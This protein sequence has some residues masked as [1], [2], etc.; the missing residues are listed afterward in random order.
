MKKFIIPLLIVVLLIS[1]VM[2][3][4]SCKKEAAETTTAAE[5]VTEET[6]ATE[7]TAAETT[8]EPK[9]SGSIHFLAY[10]W[11]AL[12]D[13]TLAKYTEATGVEVT[14]EVLGYNELNTKF[15][16]SSAAGIVA[17]DVFSTYVAP[18]AAHVA[19][20]YVEPLDSYISDELRND[21]LGIDVFTFN[22]ILYGVPTYYDITC[23]MYNKELLQNAGID[24]PPQ[25]LDELFQQCMDIKNAGVCEYPLAV[26]LAA[27]VGM[28]DRWYNIALAYGG[29]PLFDEN[30]QPQFTAKDSGGYKALEFMKQANGTIIDPALIDA[31]DTNVN[32]IFLAG[33]AVFLVGSPGLVTRAEDP[34]VSKIVGEKVGL[35]LFPGSD[36][37]RSATLN[38]Y[39]D[40]MSVSSL[41]ENK[42]AAW[43]FIEW[44]NTAEIAEDAYKDLGVTP[45]RKSLLETFINRGLV[46]G[47]TF[48]AEQSEYGMAIFQSGIPVWFDEWAQDAAGQLNKAIRG[49]MSIDEALTKMANKAIEMQE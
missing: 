34:E 36:K 8:A 39:L 30:Y 45:T 44:W 48:I 43:A 17:A 25:T 27:H 6:T 24:N 2:L 12:S 11:F 47:G 46:P 29:V 18:L 49:D 21:I 31:V 38:F 32:D 42:D 13:E 40:G 28:A 10:P 20:G 16:T 7:T 35:A 19:A 4:I 41:S 14:Q 22:G 5:T 37:T 1:L 23:L 3:N 15:V 33:D 9:L 26:P